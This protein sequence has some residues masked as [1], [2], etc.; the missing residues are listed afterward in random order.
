[1]KNKWRKLK[2]NEHNQEQQVL[3]HFF[4]R[5][6]LA[7]LKCAKGSWSSNPPN[8]IQVDGLW[9]KNGVAT[10]YKRYAPRIW[11]ILVKKVVK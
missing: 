11:G 9:L 1:M 10:K 3:E 6:D 7:G 2:N 4:L 5:K 8:A